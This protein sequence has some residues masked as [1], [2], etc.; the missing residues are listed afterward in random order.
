MSNFRLEKENEMYRVYAAQDFKAGSAN[1]PEWEPPKSKRNIEA[2]EK[3]GLIDDPDNL[4][5]ESESWIHDGAEVR[6]TKITAQ[7]KVIIGGNSRVSNAGTLTQEH[8]WDAKI[9]GP[10]DFFTVATTDFLCPDA[11]GWNDGILTVYRTS[12]GVGVS[13]LHSCCDLFSS[14]E[15]FQEVAEQ[16]AASAEGDEKEEFLRQYNNIVKIKEEKLG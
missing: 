10:D 11:E 4:A 12:N 13:Y 3:G 6:G 7:S 5:P 16:V 9:E 15:H 2:G 14:W 8:F 1:G